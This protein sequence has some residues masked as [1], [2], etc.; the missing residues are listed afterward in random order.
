MYYC[1]TGLPK[2]CVLV[3][4]VILLLGCGSREHF[5]SLQSAHQRGGK[6]FVFPTPAY[7]SSHLF[8]NAFSLSSR[9]QPWF[10]WG[11]RSFPSWEW[12]YSSR[13]CHTNT[14][15]VTCQLA[16]CSPGSCR[17]PGERWKGLHFV[18][19]SLLKALLKDE[20]RSCFL[21]PFSDICSSSSALY[22]S[23]VCLFL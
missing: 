8:H 23:Y 6:V 14:S 5:K 19:F 1:I 22:C 13:F 9:R 7:V 20:L 10:T 16:M 4:N 15:V 3:H 17:S 2:S 21:F 18:S 11:L 12:F